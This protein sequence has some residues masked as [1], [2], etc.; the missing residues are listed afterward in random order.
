MGLACTAADP[1]VAAAAEGWAETV[2]AVPVEGA[3]V[4]ETAGA[5]LTSG[6][7]IL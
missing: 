5:A 1:M 7:S 3:A 4:V 6:N 2:C